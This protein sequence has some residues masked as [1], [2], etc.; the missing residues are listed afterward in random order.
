MAINQIMW[1][2]GGVAMPSPSSYKISF[3]DVDNETYRSVVDASLVRDR[4]A[5]EFCKIQFSYRYLTPEN[6]AKIRNAI[7]A[8]QE[9]T[10]NAVTPI[11]GNLTFKAYCSKMEFEMLECQ[12]GYSASFSVIQT[13]K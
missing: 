13:E 11:F 10:V 6:A 9:F 8:N 2:V 3:E 5:Q 12:L 7:K 4:I 1:S